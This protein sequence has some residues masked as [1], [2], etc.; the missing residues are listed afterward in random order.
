MI[1]NDNNYPVQQPGKSTFEE[2]SVE[3]KTFIND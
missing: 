3:E 2:C 1:E